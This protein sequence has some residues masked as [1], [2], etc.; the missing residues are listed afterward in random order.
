M[1]EVRRDIY[2]NEATGARREDFDE[3]ARQIGALLA[4]LVADSTCEI[5][6]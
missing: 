5:S 1:I 4:A 6:S 2:M 3:T